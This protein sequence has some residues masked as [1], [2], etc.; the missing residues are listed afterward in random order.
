[1]AKMPSDTKLLDWLQEQ[2]EGRDDLWI[3]RHSHRR[4]WRLYQ[5][6]VTDFHWQDASFDIREAI[7]EAMRRKRIK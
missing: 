7:V 5:V 3:C 6:G 4:G 2:G 1:M